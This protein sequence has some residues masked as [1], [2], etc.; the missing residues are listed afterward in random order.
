MP[1]SLTSVWHSSTPVWILSPSLS[2]WPARARVRVCVCVSVRLFIAAVEPLDGLLPFSLFTYI[3][4]VRSSA[5]LAVGNCTLLRDTFCVGM[6][7]AFGHLLT[8]FFFSLLPFYAVSFPSGSRSFRCAADDTH[9]TCF[10]VCPSAPF[11]LSLSSFLY[12][13]IFIC[14]YIYILLL[15][16]YIYIYMPLSADFALFLLLYIYSS[17][18]SACFRLFFCCARFPLFSLPLSLPLRV[19]LSLPSAHVSVYACMSVSGSAS[20]CAWSPL[21]LLG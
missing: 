19:S 14:T 2:T 5:S 12:I 6:S 11:S 4:Y 7:S 16:L 9:K 20:G 21:A 8:F 1:L 3:W 13:S 15:S 17:H 10:R 18:I